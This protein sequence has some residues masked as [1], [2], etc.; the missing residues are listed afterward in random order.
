MKAWVV[1]CVMPL[2]LASHAI[3]AQ[4]EGRGL[5]LVYDRERE[6]TIVGTVERLVEKPTPGTPA[7]SHLFVSASGRSVDVHVGPYVSSELKDPPIVGQ[8]VQVTGVVENIQ[9]RRILLARRLRFAGHE[10]TIRTEH[11]LLLRGAAHRRSH[12]SSLPRSGGA[13]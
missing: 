12:V 11:G 8:P 1:A 7:G 6:I 2:M 3:A 13:Q 5:S 9:G 4:A 10:L